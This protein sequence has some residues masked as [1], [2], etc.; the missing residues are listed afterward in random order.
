VSHLEKRYRE[1]GRD[2]VIALHDVDVTIEP[3]SFVT[4]V[5]PSGCG[6]STLLRILAGT[7][8]RTSGEVAIGGRGVS[9]PTRE[10]GSFS[11][12]PSCCRGGPSWPTLP[13]LRRS[14]VRI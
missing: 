8:E 14:R 5:G 7:L 13:C 6:K 9:G 10:L 3:G 11:N 2:E 1:P 4:V 12:L